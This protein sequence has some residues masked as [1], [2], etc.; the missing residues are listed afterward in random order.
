MYALGIDIGGTKVALAVVDAHGTILADTR[1]P[2]DTTLAPA[3][4]ID[5]I[6]HAAKDLIQQAQVDMVN[7]KG[8][9]IG[10]PGP[11]NVKTGEITSPPNLKNWRH[12][13]IVEQFKQS[14]DLPIRLENDAN[15][16]AIAEKWL[17]AGVGATDFVYLTISTGIGAGI[18]AN[19][20]LL[21]GAKGNAGDFGHTV[22]D[23]SFGVCSCGQRGCLE[24]ICSGT[25]ISR[26]GS[27]IKGETLTTQEV[28]DLYLANDP[29]I[30]PYMISVLETL[31]AAVVTLINTFDPDRI[32]LGGGV[33]KVGKPL[34]D[35]VKAYVSK[36]TLNPDASDTPVV[37][38]KLDQNAG[39]IGAAGLIL[40]EEEQ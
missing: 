1:I 4:M 19:N 37:L 27:R 39:V 16:A 14:F 29:E 34:F 26:E 9:G 36:Y 28:F 18:I 13:K 23:P 20:Q 3:L 12:V 33:T 25:A 6:I 24:H 21:T 30:T 35:A 10:A 38:A 7:L 11:L 8:I 2:T 22:I 15:A 32:I 31:G 5:K 17:G 40:I